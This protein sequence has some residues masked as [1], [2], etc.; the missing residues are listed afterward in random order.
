[1]TGTS[2]PGVDAAAEPDEISAVLVGGS[3]VPA[4]QVAADVER[5]TDGVSVTTVT[6]PDAAHDALDAGVDCVLVDAA[7]EAR[8]VAALVRDVRD[9]RPGLP[10]LVLAAER[11]D[12]AVGDVVDAG[13]TDVV[14][15]GSPEWRRLL[16]GR[17]EDAVAAR[18]RADRG[19]EGTVQEALERSRA[20]FRA[21]I[22]NSPAVVSVLDA[23]GRYRYVSPAA[24][25]VAGYEPR[26]LVGDLAFDYVH[27]ADREKTEREFQR[28]VAD[29]SHAPVVEHRFRHA[30]G[31]WLTVESRGRNRLDDPNVEGFIVNTR[32]VTRYKQAAQRLR[33]ERD[34]T[35]RIFEVSPYPLVVLDRE[36]IVRRVNDR[37]DEQ[38]AMDRAEVIGTG[39]GD[40][41][42]TVLDDDGEPLADAETLTGR[43]LASGET[44]HD[45]RYRVVT[46]DGDEYRV[47]ASGAP[48]SR[49][50]EVTHAVLA[51][52]DIERV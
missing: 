42:F 15:A 13:A 37:F 8:S 52:H 25:S 49:D 50:G 27:P 36:G 12:V 9:E 51:F 16:G 30:D 20:K 48:I 45:V 39:S 21:L 11:A 22:E 10:V 40:A 24:K 2:D 1:M 32:D 19:A 44:I 4:S 46:P 26:E 31:H 5:T 38:V 41:E 18:R 43:V 33:G 3:A 6:E 28:A 14:R 35:H 34:L 47:T 7:P 23:T 17:I 29:P